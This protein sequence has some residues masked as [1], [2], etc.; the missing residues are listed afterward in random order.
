MSNAPRELSADELW[1]PCDPTDF[2]F[3]TTAALPS[4]APIIGQQ[5]AVQAID[6]GVGIASHGFNVYA[7]GYTGTGRTTTT[8]T[9]LDRVAASQPVPSDWIYV[10]NF[11]D[12]NQPNA[13]SLPPGTAVQL[14]RDME[15]LVS[16]L[17]REIPRAFE[18]EDYAQQREKILRSLQ[19]QRNEMFAQ[20][21]HRVNEQGFTL[22]KTAMGLGIAPVL[23]GQVLTPEAYQQLD[24]TTRQGIE[25]RQRQLQGEMAETMRRIRDLEKAT[26]RQLRDFDRQIA[27]FAVGH[28]IE[29]LKTRY[30]GIA[31]VPEYL[32]A[33][34]ADIIEHVDGFRAQEEAGEGLSAAM[35]ASQREA[36]LKRYR[37]NVLVDHSQQQG[38]PVIVEPSPTYGNLLG[39][40]E[41]RAEFGALVTDFTMIKA[42]CLHRANGGYLVLEMHRLLAN[43][44]AWD[45][46]KRALKNSQ[47]RIEEVGTHLQ[48]ISTVTLEPEPI[49]LDVKVVLIGDPMAYYLLHEYDEDFRKLFKVQ[50]DFGTYFERRPETCQNYARFIAARCH[51][52]DLLPFD[53]SAVARAV[54]YG[55]RLAEHQH[56]LSTRFGEIADLVREASYWAQQRASDRTTARDV[57]RAIDERTYRANRAEEQTQ[58]LIGEGTLH[59]D[60][61]GQAVGQVNGLSVLSLGNYSFGKPSRITVQTYTGRSGVVSLE[62]ETKLSGRIHDKGLLTL[63]GYLG[64]KYAHDRPLSLSASISFEQLYDEI[65]GDSASSTELYA[66]LSSLARLPVRQGIAITGSVDQRGNIQPIGG[67]NE[68]I[69]GFFQTCKRLGLT[70][71]QGVIL[72]EQNVVHLMLRAEVRQAVA[73]G[74]FHIYPVSTV[75]EGIEILTG[76]PAGDLEQ[77]GTYPPDSVHGRVMAR[78]AE[79][80]ENLKTRGEEEEEEED[81]EGP[82]AT[83]REEQEGAE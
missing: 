34:Q 28:L 58:E 56:K 79:I 40:L 50:A 69:E 83:H 57:Q 18:S 17:L 65:E 7:L 29:D 68:K 80:A 43:P 48:L 8:R 55:S 22:L 11:A 78:L 24:E 19:E 73:E 76:V 26:K 71:E 61:T 27:T 21:E 30:G 51:Q 35:V 13:I 33:A 72:P 64:G 45:G 14:R 63:S 54:E 15:E 59:V 70:G 67:A 16:D 9:F 1:N 38:A 12:P 41:H 66:L 5:R 36:L 49:P 62:R 32:A 4:E 6:F 37:I 77:D 25:E 60:V 2:S 23:N 53:P 3:E 20:L 31:E 81:R 52:E 44:V 46:L 74:R 47:I 42:G 39:R 10:Y 75:D 82:S